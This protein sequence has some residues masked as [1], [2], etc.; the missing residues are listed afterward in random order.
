MN[1]MHGD[2]FEDII[3]HEAAK[4]VLSKALLR[5]QNGYLFLGPGGVGCRAMAERFARALAGHA[6]DRPLGAHPD[7][8]V[9]EREMSESGKSRKDISVKQVR[10]L[11]ERMSRR[12]GI[13]ERMVAYVPEADRLNE[14]GVNAL[15]KSLEEPPARAVFVFAAHQEARLPATLLSRLSVL[16]FGRVRSGEML[17]WLEGMGV[18][19]AD[20]RQAIA[21]AQGRPGA[22]LRFIRDPDARLSVE[23]ADNV[24][25]RM[26]EAERLGDALAAA[27]EQASACD[28]AEDPVTEWR[29]TL[30]L[31]QTALRRRFEDHPAKA[32]GVA[33]ALLMAERS[34]GGSVSPRIWME[35]GL[36]RAV[37]DKPPVFRSF[38][39]GTY[40][41]PID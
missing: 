16:R 38:V 35:L 31:W 39:P 29:N 41:Y 33:Y 24:I 15:L 4:E 26:L 2:I 34:I 8:A 17:S 10:D 18:G 25:V 21:F 13:A 6:F 22:A 3:G 20:R 40:P 12:P 14:E 11:R 32:H 36:V 27:A 9:L 37:L 28:A 5:P 30:Q 1:F 23:R 7:L 19:E